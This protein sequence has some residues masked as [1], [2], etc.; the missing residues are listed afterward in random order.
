MIT[1]FKNIAKNKKS[2]IFLD[3]ILVSGSNFLLGILLA[4]FLGLDIFGQFSLLWLI[5]LFFSSIQLALII[6]PLLTHAPKKNKLIKD[7]YLTNMLYMQFIFSIICVLIL[8]I[9]F[10]FSELITS[11]YN[12]SEFRYYIL[13]M[14]FS[15]LC[16]DFIRRYFIIKISYFRLIFIDV[17][18]YI[19]QLIGISSLIF[20]EQLTLIN[21]FISISLTFTISF[22]VGYLQINFKSL[23]STHIKLLFL[24]NWKFSKWLVYSS[25]LQWGSGNFYILVAGS[26]LGPWSV[27]VIKVMQN[28]MGIFHVIFIAL[29]NI[30]P[31]RFAEIYKNNGYQKTISF[32]KIQLQYGFYIFLVLIS[33]LFIYGE[34]LILV[35]YG[36]EYV[37]YSYLLFGFMIM[38]IFIYIGMLQ[39]YILRT[40]E[41][42]KKIF[43]NYIITTI[44]SVI[45]SF[46]L[47]KTLEINGVVIGMILT[48]ILTS[49][50]FFI[51]IKKISLKSA[52]D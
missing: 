26:I 31:I 48:Q 47:I 21:T 23:K 12:I 16:Q 44:F 40:I 25:L 14:V 1:K 13:W 37:S 15:F 46:I 5:V 7:Y 49:I 43:I 9:L 27:G 20:F 34:E 29:E 28:T 36:D 52:N 41:N 2:L 8:S 39:R 33:V 30:L 51:E 6:S 10:Y 32:F 17:I 35:I 19:G 50:I 38:Y 4:R 3:Q 42:T 11:K 45:A 22:A 18:A 24:K